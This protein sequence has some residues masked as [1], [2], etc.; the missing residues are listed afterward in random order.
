MINFPEPNRFQKVPGEPGV[1]EAREKDPTSRVQTV[2]RC[3]PS[4]FDIHRADSFPDNTYTRLI[5]QRMGE[6]TK[7]TI[8]H[9]TLHRNIVLSLNNTGTPQAPDVVVETNKKPFYARTEYSNDKLVSVSI[10][11][12]AKNMDDLVS[13]IAKND[14]CTHMA[15]LVSIYGHGW[16]AAFYPYAKKLDNPTTALLQTQEAVLDL[17]TDTADNHWSELS[18]LTVPPRFEILT[19][20]LL[21]MGD[22]TTTN[23]DQH[24]YSALFGETVLHLPEQANFSNE[25]LE[26]ALRVALI[27]TL[28]N[29]YLTLENFGDSKTTFTPLSNDK[30]Y[31]LLVEDPSTHQVFYREQLALGQ[32]VDYSEYTY[33]IDS[34]GD[35]RL[36]IGRFPKRGKKFGA[37]LEVPKTLDAKN[38]AE[39]AETPSVTGWEKTIAGREIFLTRSLLLN[40]L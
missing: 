27:S 24:F 14:P 25:E 9:R 40:L 3:Y 36:K 32:T 21:A 38:L 20:L 23:L 30:G 5:K 34:I 39:I 16:L 37:Y 33:S 17:T 8:E 2:W 10:R 1:L 19:R 29:Y 12:Q 15:E 4:L 22:I 18:R 31:L 28:A 11:E 35:N 13:E 26:K 6:P 7:I